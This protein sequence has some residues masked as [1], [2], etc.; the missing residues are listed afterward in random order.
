MTWQLW[1]IGLLAA[2]ASLGGCDVAPNIEIYNGVGRALE[3]EVAKGEDPP[4]A[5]RLQPGESVRI[6]N[7]MGPDLRLRF[8]GCERR[9]QLPYMAWNHPWSVPDGQGGSAPDYDHTYPVSV[10]L[11][12]DFRLYLLPGDA[13]VP[14]SKLGPAQAHGYPL[15]PVFDGCAGRK[16]VSASHGA[17]PPGVAL[18]SSR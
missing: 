9:Y 1:A 8:E 5:A 11:G 14:P 18:A 13:V 4:K 16:G 6:W 15:R 2:A 7:I 3:L 12:A 10:Q 17:G